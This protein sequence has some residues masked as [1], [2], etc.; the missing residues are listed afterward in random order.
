MGSLIAGVWSDADN[1]MDAG[2]Y[3]RAP[4]VFN[5][6]LSAG[7]IAAMAAQPGRFHL[8]ASWSC[9][10]SHRT[11]LVRRLKGLEKQIPLHITGGKRV[12]GYPA[13]SGRPWQ[14]PGSNKQIVHLHQLYSL[15]HPQYSGR[16]TVPVLWDSQAL[17]IVSNE[18]ASIVRALDAVRQND[19][20]IGSDRS[21]VGG[22]DFCLAP[23]SLAAEIDELNGYIYQ[24]LSNAIYRAGKA[25]SQSAYEEAVGQVFACM[26]WLENRLGGQRFLLGAAITEADW[27]LFP[28]LVRFD[29]DYVMHSRCSYKR[30]LD[31]PHLWAYAR[32]LY[33]W[34]GIAETINFEAIHLS[35][36]V[37]GSVIPV[38][39]CVDWSAP[40]QR[41]A[42]GPV[43]V[44][45]RTGENLE[46]EDGDTDGLGCS[47]PAS[48][49]A[50][51]GA[52][53]R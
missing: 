4:S 49:P 19:L 45:L 9:P 24:H 3:V 43:S 27:L 46:I 42:L 48:V 33:R 30:L 11:M 52:W 6:A 12:E 26:D 21:L 40:Q 14:V 28:T 51:L 15:S 44:Y 31:Y 47:G 34:P 50:A 53:G 23:G 37:E 18:S 22:R 35:N 20:A 5:Q 25:Q 8:I 10:W 7:I 17:R 36:V 38:M 13:N 16:A 41:A 32:D 29:L 39:P 2:A 1:I